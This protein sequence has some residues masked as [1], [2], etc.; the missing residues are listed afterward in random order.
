MT[1]QDAMAG[2]EVTDTGIPVA[3]VNAFHQAYG[4][5]MSSFGAVESSLMMVVKALMRPQDPMCAFNAFRSG[6][7]FKAQLDMIAV[8]VETVFEDEGVLASWKSLKKRIE[9]IQQRRNTIAHMHV[10]H[11]N[12]YVPYGN[13]PRTQRI[14]LPI[15][16][17][18][19]RARPEVI[20]TQ[21][22]VE[23]KTATIA[24][25]DAIYD[26]E[27]DVERALR[28]DGTPSS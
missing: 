24:V 13:T 8:L 21:K 4:E 25:A 11:M 5:A 27:N 9:H 6:M 17:E 15:E 12:R 23:I 28:D 7:G 16:W 10:W 3:V 26:F 19:R 2:Q 20:T 14:D 22:L 1:D 18:D